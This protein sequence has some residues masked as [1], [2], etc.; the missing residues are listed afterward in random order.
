MT[1]DQRQLVWLVC[2]L[3]FIVALVAGMFGLANWVQRGK[4]QRCRVLFPQYTQA[5]CEWL[6]APTWR[7]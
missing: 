5:Q 4:A 3:A 2:Y 1:R 7:Q 6:A